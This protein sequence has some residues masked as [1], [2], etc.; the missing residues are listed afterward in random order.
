MADCSEEQLLELIT[1]R[2]ADGREMS[3]AE[4]PL[5]QQPG[6]CRDGARR[7]DDA[8]GARRSQRHHAGQRHADPSGR[9]RG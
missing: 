9:R 7:G 3:L 4:F 6:Q 8:L 2:R 1:C 5:A